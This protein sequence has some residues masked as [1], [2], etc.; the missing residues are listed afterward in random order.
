M[1]CHEP[2]TDADLVRLLGFG[3]ITAWIRSRRRSLAGHRR[4]DDDYTRSTSRDR[5]AAHGARESTLL[6]L[7]STFY[8]WDGNH[9]A[10]G[11]TDAVQFKSG[12]PYATLVVGGGSNDVALEAP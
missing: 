9:R 6:A 11:Y 3:A 5:P 8:H 12:N 7:A 1:A 4:E 10:R 2:L